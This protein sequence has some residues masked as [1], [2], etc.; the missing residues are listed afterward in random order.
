MTRIVIDPVSRIEGRL[1][2]EAQV[3]HAQVTDA[4]SSSTMFRG[5]E[6]VLQG[7]DP[8]DAWTF[9]QRLCGGCAT[10][11]ALCSVRAVEHALQIQ[12]PENAGLVRNI[13][14]AIQHIQ[15]H[16]LHFYHL[17]ALDWVDINRA[18]DA[19]PTQAAILAQSVS[20]WPL[21]SP[22]YFSAVKERVVA[23]FQSKWT[24]MLRKGYR[25]HPAYKMPAEAS[26]M[27]MAHYLQALDWQ[28]DVGRIQT[29]GG[30]RRPHVQ[31]FRVGGVARSADSPLPPDLN[32]Q[33][34]MQLSQLFASARAFIEKVYLR[35]LM[36][37]ASFY[38][39]WAGYGCG[40][41]NYMAYGEFPRVA[42]EN[43]GGAG[44]FF[45]PGGVILNRDLSQVHTLDRK[46]IAQHMADSRP[47]AASAGNSRES[48]S[49]LG[50]PRYNGVPVEVGPLARMLIA[51]A[52][53]HERARFWIQ[54]ML[55]ELEME[56]EALF[57]TLG[58]ML[59][60]GIETVVLADQVRGWLGELATNLDRGELHFYNAEYWEPE[61]WRPEAMGFGWAEAPHGALSHRVDIKDGAI[62]HYQCLVP[63]AWNTS[64]RDASGHRGACEAALLLTPIA[65]PERP[66]EILRT[67][68]SFDPC[69]VWAVHL[70][71]PGWAGIGQQRG[72]G[73]LESHLPGEEQPRD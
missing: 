18:Q 49:W 11:H 43:G 14:T 22:H 53:G 23:V 62:A 13:V 3:E 7:Q 17:H 70:V 9:A 73:T 52:S 41:G 68:H 30:D 56:T 57:S 33:R 60:R 44:S 50:S 4:W 61:T 5:L 2:I 59:A 71:D 51:Y 10:S 15:D 42:N 46:T 54:R 29:L 16:I 28:R 34:L 24:D 21:S 27:I 19:D 25:G 26:L 55:A 58:R 39:D 1:R 69:L 31:T 20:D 65:D 32:T 67:I 40:L 6:L 38:R 66:I 8:R 35:D 63:T 12:I 45:L 48:R 64:P 72:G 37:I 36:A 47:E